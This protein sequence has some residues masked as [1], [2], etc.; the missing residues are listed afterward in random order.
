MTL[1]LLTNLAHPYDEVAARYDE[2]WSTPEARAEDREIMRTI[3]YRD[4]L[5]LDIGCGTGLFLDHHRNC[6]NYIGVDPSQGMIDQLSKKHGSRTTLCQTFE[7][8]MPSLASLRFNR[9]I[10]LFGSP[11]YIKPSALIQAKEWLKPGGWMFCMFI[12]P[13]YNP[14]THAYIAEPPPMFDHVPAEYG[15][16]SRF[17]NYIVTRYQA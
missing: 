2:L 3:N 8:A 12:A 14:E 10:S 6:S 16:W 7:D 13:D 1:Q 15:A 4:G 11:S 17:G 9:I 5:V